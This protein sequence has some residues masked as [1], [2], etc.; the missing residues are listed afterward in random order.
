MK[1]DL[2]CGVVRDLLPACVEG[3]TSQE[4]NEAVAAH[5]ASCPDCAAI[6]QAMT[7]PEKIAAEQERE[8]DYLRMVKRK[9]GHRVIRAIL[10][11]G[12]LFVAGLAVSVF[13][14]GQPV[15][16]QGVAYHLQAE[17][18]VLRVGVMS[19]GSANALIGWKAEIENGDVRISGRSVLVSSLH[20]GGSAVVEVPL[21]GV[22]RIYLCGELVWQDGLAVQQTT[23]WLYQVKTPY[24]GDA[25]ALRRI[26]DRMPT[27]ARWGN[28]TSELQT[29]QEP[30]RWTLHFSGGTVSA[31]E[32]AEEMPRYASLLLALVE[33]LGEVGWTHAAGDGTT[34]SGVITLE[35]IN[36]WLPG[37]VDGYNAAHGTNWSVLAN[38]K[39]YADS[40]AL[41]QQLVELSGIS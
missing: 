6:K 10:L 17:E 30:Y 36:A 23:R 32:M 16:Y 38:V 11:T 26:T 3:L 33:N 12:L 7:A 1:N 21:A 2:T 15:S 34:Q 8:V 25:P 28:Y 40:P 31:E 27:P 19:M 18:D 29:A 4:T 24:V 22:S 13:L 37:W 41:L 14:V 9:Q 20:R 39:E 35:D 5:L